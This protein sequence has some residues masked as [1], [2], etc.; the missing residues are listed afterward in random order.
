MSPRFLSRW[1]LES[2][3]RAQSAGPCHRQG[4]NPCAEQPKS[5]SR[6]CRPTSASACPLQHLPSSPQPP[7]DLPLALALAPPFF[8][9]SL[10][11]TFSLPPDLPPSLPPPS[12][13]PS[14]PHARSLTR[15]HALALALSLALSVWLS[16]A[17]SQFARGS[18]RLK[19]TAS[20][21][22]SRTVREVEAAAKC[23]KKRAQITVEIDVHA[24][25]RA[26]MI[27]RREETE[28]E[29]PLQLLRPCLTRRNNFISTE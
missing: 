5:C 24:K 4:R 15:A 10:P 28:Q 14:L 13:P 8:P 9:P 23:R 6:L 18:R 20:E 29:C 2:S 25:K 16:R 19:L 12:L 11:P 3:L 1:G 21:S 27:S 26:Q 22:Q 17:L 7:L